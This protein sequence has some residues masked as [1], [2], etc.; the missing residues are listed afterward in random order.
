MWRSEVFHTSKVPLDSNQHTATMLTHILHWMN[1]ARVLDP[2]NGPYFW[3]VSLLILLRRTTWTLL[4]GCQ[5][6]VGLS[7]GL[8]TPAWGAKT[9]A[10][11]PARTMLPA[12]LFTWEKCHLSSSFELSLPYCLC[13]RCMNDMKSICS[14]LSGWTSFAILNSTADSAN[15][16]RISV[17]CASWN[18]EMVPVSLPDVSAGWQARTQRLDSAK[19]VLSWW[20]PLVIT[21][22]FYPDLRSNGKDTFIFVATAVIDEFYLG[23][24]SLP[25]HFLTPLYYHLLF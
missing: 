12:L 23:K 6:R 15:T 1:E 13:M 5:S 22:K 9:L 2:A 10:S 21:I 4:L 3:L 25:I 16:F 8:L 24:L 7:I 18:V 19:F 14:C 11:F 20:S 17:D